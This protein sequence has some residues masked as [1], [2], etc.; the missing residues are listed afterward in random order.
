VSGGGGRG[1]APRQVLSARPWDCRGRPSWRRRFRIAVAELPALGTRYR[2]LLLPLR[3]DAAESSRIAADLSGVFVGVAREGA[4]L[5]QLRSPR[6]VAAGR[7]CGIAA[8]CSV[9]RGGRE[10]QAAEHVATAAG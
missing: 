9:A 8:S 6:S 10:A 7:V 4:V 2:Q 3:R 5:R 1:R